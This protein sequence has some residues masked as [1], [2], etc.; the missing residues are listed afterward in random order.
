MARL[1]V[2]QGLMATFPSE[3]GGGMRWFGNVS[4]EE[5]MI[6]TKASV[7]SVKESKW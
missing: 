4:G 6:R 5:L 3:K 7:K 2:V 1:G